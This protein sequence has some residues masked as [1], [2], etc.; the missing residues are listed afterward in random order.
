MS[1]FN[2][3][4]GVQ[5]LLSIVVFIVCWDFPGQDFKD[6]INAFAVYAEVILPLAVGL[7]AGYKLTGTLCMFPSAL[8][9]ASS[10][11]DVVALGAYI[12]QLVESPVLIE[13]F[14]AKGILGIMCFQE[15]KRQPAHVRA[16]GYGVSKGH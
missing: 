8:F 10:V 12:A 9:G 2:T 5:A 13:I 11:V 6:E 16:V 3:F 1:T 7:I 14:V 15:F 4:A